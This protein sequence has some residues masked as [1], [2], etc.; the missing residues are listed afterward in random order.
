MILRGSYVS[1]K[2]FAA[3][4]REAIEVADGNEIPATQFELL[5]AGALKMF[6][7]AGLEWAVLEAGLGA[8][9]DATSA[10]EPETV[11]LTNVGLDHTEYLG[12]TVEEITEEKLASLK[13]GAT[14]VLGTDDPRMVGVAR[15]T[16]TRVG[17]RLVEHEAS[18]DLYFG[19]GEIP[20]LARNER[21]GVRV[22]EVLL[23]RPLQ[24]D[25]REA[26]LKLARAAR[27]PARFEVHEVRGVPV[28][29]DGS[30]NPEG[31]RAALEAVRVRYGD[32]P[33]GVVFGALKDKD[34]G[35]MLND[36]ERVAHVLVLT[37]PE[38]TDRRVMDPGQ[39]EEEYSPKD[40]K[41]R[42]A[43][44]TSDAGRALRAVVGEMEKTGGVVLVTGSLYMGAGALGWL[45]GR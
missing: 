13:S 42:R 1:E 3:A 22:A 32:R 19:A 25:E 5:T 39:V 26:A 11:V 24:R 44:V 45:R 8:R 15:D 2:E 36:L 12:D 29:V 7:D 43:L 38:I 27:P 31:L 28:V 30:H 17:A 23:G 16:A 20:Y 35:S 4:M 14:L 10:A 40:A 41:G 6:R 37:R 34:V 33:L 18:G 21:L 9:H